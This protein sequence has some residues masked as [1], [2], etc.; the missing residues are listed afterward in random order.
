MKNIVALAPVV[1]I[2][3]LSAAPV[4]SQMK[5]AKPQPAPAASEEK[6]VILKQGERP[7]ARAGSRSLAN[8]DARHC[9]QLTTNMAIHRCA[10]KYRPR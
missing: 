2:A 3:A 10:E 7:A 8:V 1:L 4:M 6:G 5:D 9:L